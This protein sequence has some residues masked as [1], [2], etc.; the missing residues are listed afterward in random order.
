MQNFFA[1]IGKTDEEVKA[2]IEKDFNTI[3]FGPEKIYHENE[4]NGKTYGY[5]LDTGNFDVR[6]EGQSYGMM[7]AVMLDRRD[8]F[9]RIWDFSKDY[10]LIKEGKNKGY[11]GWSCQPN[12]KLN[13][14]GPAPDGEEFFAMALIFAANRW[15]DEKGY[16]QSARDILHAMIHNEEPM[17]N[18]D[19]LIKFVPGMQTSDP[20]YHLPHF[21]EYFAQWANDED[22]EF[23]KEA[24]KA[25]RAYLAKACHPGTGLS[26]EYADFD[27]KPLNL[28]NHHLFY[29]DAYRVGLNISLDALWFGAAKFHKTQAANILKFF[30]DIKK[31]KTVWRIDGT[32]ADPEEQVVERNGGV[33]GVLHPLGLL[34]TIA[35]SAALVDIPEGEFY[36]KEIWEAEPRTDGRRYYDNLLYIFSMMLL[37]GDYK[38]W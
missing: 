7:I 3:F 36:L 15:G 14:Q 34:S 11:F 28:N 37:S 21:Y 12:G 8:I 29:S 25:S 9:D 30:A 23:F 26:A 33:L 4:I 32:K 35:A 10:M 6:T 2:R 13:S 20:S 22:K 24:A 1:K 16:R 17:F 27:G 38:P 5:M 31:I 19:K 18:E